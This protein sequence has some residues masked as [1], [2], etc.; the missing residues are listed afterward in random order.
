[1]TKSTLSIPEAAAEL[2][3][4]R[5]AAYEAARRGEIPILRFGRRLRVPRAALDRMLE[6]AKPIKSIEEALAGGRLKGLR[7]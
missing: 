2:G 6:E 7:F 5:S 3:I 4:G 1:M